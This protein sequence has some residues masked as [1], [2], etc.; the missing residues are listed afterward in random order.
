MNFESMANNQNGQENGL[1]KKGY[2]DRIEEILEYFPEE[3]SERIEK[4]YDEVDLNDLTQ[5]KQFYNQMKD[6]WEKRKEFLNQKFTG[7]NPKEMTFHDNLPPNLRQKTNEL[8]AALAE[9]LKENNYEE[10][11]FGKTATVRAVD[12]DAPVCYKYIN[13]EEEYKTN[14]RIDKEMELQN[15]CLDIE[16]QGND[17]RVPQ[18]Y[19]YSMDNYTHFCVMENIQGYTIEQILN[20]EGELM[21][22]F[23]V[24]KFFD[25]IKEFIEKM[26]ETGIYHRDL[27]NRNIMIECTGGKPVI[28][29]FGK[30]TNTKQTGYTENPYIEN[31]IIYDNDLESL[32]NI[33]AEV[34]K[35]LKNKG[36]Q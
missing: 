8:L 23:N 34:K 11:G 22:D 21:D 10:L 3:L 27:H 24:D 5:I 7:H 32:K 28:I 18:P 2:I 33:K 13:N 12:F 4:E 6:K 30:S 1:S 25:D 20:G 31:N 17:C 19:Y 29:D 36:E 9:E 14:N 35:F 15:K 26:H 16:I